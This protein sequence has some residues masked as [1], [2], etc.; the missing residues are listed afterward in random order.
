MDRLGNELLAG[1]AFALNQYRGA[2][3]RNLPDQVENAQHG[4]ALT[5]DVFEVVA[6]LES[7]LELLV[8][9]FGA[10]TGDGCAYVSQ[11]LLVVPRLFN[12]VGGALLHGADGV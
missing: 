5:H 9:F 7:A 4:F 12:E 2:A 1:A 8:F 3:G 10:A 6:L 11:E